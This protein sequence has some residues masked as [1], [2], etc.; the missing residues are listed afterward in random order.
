MFQ[1]KSRWMLAIFITFWIGLLYVAL[2]CTT[3]IYSKKVKIEDNRVI[4][5]FNR[6]QQKKRLLKHAKMECIELYQLGDQKNQSYLYIM[7]A[8]FYSLYYTLLVVLFAFNIYVSSIDQDVTSFPVLTNSLYTIQTVT[9]I[10]EL[11]NS[12]HYTRC[13]N[14]S[15]SA[16][17]WAVLYSP[18]T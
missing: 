16:F 3:D 1:K 13:Y 9:K 12:S 18:K 11:G 8:S 14:C 6:N 7:W 17:I 15:T 5:H 4:S 10:F 2:Y